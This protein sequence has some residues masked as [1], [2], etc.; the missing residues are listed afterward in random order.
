MSESAGLLPCE[1]YERLLSTVHLNDSLQLLIPNLIFHTKK[2]KKDI[3][4]YE[5]AYFII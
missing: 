3:Q 2:K 4:V 5:E 1:F